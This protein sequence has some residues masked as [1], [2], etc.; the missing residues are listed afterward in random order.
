M[1]KFLYYFYSNRN[2]GIRYI[3]YRVQNNLC[4]GTDMSPGVGNIQFWGLRRLRLSRYACIKA[5]RFNKG[6]DNGVNCGAQNG[7]M[8]VGKME[9]NGIDVAGSLETSWGLAASEVEGETSTLGSDAIFVSFCL[10]ATNETTLD[11][12]RD[13]GKQ[14]YSLSVDFFTKTN[15]LKLSLLTAWTLTFPVK[16]RILTKTTPPLFFSR[17]LEELIRRQTTFWHWNQLP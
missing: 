12:L 8:F 11:D 1:Y 16:Q 17:F 13:S 14:N 4:M 10:G 2:K 15:L 6:L 9:G 7:E 3:M 5:S